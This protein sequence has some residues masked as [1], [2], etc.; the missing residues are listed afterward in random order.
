MSH[1]H[2]LCKRQYNCGAT[3]HSHWHLLCK[4]RYNCGDTDHS[5]W[6]LL[7]K[8]QYNCGDTDYSH[9]HLLCKRQY[10]CGDTDHSHWHLLCKRQYNCGDTDHRRRLRTV[11]DGCRRLR[12]QTQL[13]ANTASP[14]D[15]QV[16]REPSLRIREKTN[17]QNFCQRKQTH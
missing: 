17:I 12:S 6:H 10:N 13:L 11:A 3:D 2:V 1:R 15:P 7:C 9:W 5:H 16:K 14:P 8:R 4:R